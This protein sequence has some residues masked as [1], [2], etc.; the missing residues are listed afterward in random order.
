MNREQYEDTYKA[1]YEQKVRDWLTTNKRYLAFVHVRWQVEDPRFGDAIMTRLDSEHGWRIHKPFSTPDDVL[2]FFDAVAK[3][4]NCK[5]SLFGV[6]DVLRDK[7]MG[8]QMIGKTSD[9]FAAFMNEATV[10]S[11]AKR[12]FLQ[13][14]RNQD[15][16]EEK[17]NALARAGLRS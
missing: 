1:E 13:E 4:P 11:A 7:D 17:K 6:S 3:L 14:A 2:A 16:A 8:G 10:E 12:W 9:G 5:P 15:I